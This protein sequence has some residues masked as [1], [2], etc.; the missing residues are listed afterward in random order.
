MAFIFDW[1]SKKIDKIFKRLEI[2]KKFYN[3]VVDTDTLL[4]HDITMILSVREDSGKTT[5]TLLKYLSMYQYLVEEYN[6]HIP[7][8]YERSDK[9]QIT[10]GNIQTLFA[11]I[12]QFGYVEKLTQGKYNNIVYKHMEHKFYFSMRK[13]INDE[14]IEELA[15]D[16]FCHAICLEK[17]L[18]YKSTVNAPYFGAIF[19]EFMDTNRSKSRQMVELM[20]NVS[21]FG[22]VL[23]RLDSNGDPVFK[24][25]LLGNNTMKYNQ[26]FEE[27]CI[28]KEIDNLKF[29]SYIERKT[30]LGTTF[31]CMLL[32]KS[33]DMKEKHEKKKIHFF[34]FN[35]PKM[36]AFNGLQEWQTE[37]YQH[38]L[39][40]DQ[41][42]DSIKLDEYLIWHRHR[43]IKITLYMHDDIGIFAYA[44]YCKKPL[45][46][47]Y[48]ILT[49]TP[50]EK[51]HVYGFGAYHPQGE[52]LQTLVNVI[53]SHQLYFASN[54]VGDLF[55]DFT[56]T[57]NKN[58]IWI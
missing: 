3:M 42:N 45:Y 2:P 43:Y 11:T 12:C 21:T 22:R 54:S 29:G 34:G 36:N 28:E 1:D 53:K 39:Y 50:Q 52:N 6:L 33:N 47:D 27:F 25:C 4:N 5:N 15:P 18:D 13:Q 8:C 55:N 20:N 57:L 31:C 44:H 58:K 9:D 17:Y 48:I 24:L 26:W 35:T 51:N 40:N 30:E 46:D 41:I 38:L 23:D 37:V 56:Q 16:Y 7:F 10:V 14:V 49:T 19:D 32:Q